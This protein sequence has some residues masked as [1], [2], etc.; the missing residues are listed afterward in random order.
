VWNTPDAFY[1]YKPADARVAFTQDLGMTSAPS[2][3][4]LASGD[5]TFFYALSTERLTELDSDVL[6]SYADTAEG[7]KE[8]S[9]PPPP[10]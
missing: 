10:R 8:F 4:R 6:V 3:E 2:V 7:S 1:V 5:E 9:T